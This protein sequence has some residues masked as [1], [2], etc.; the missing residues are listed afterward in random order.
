MKTGFKINQ[1]L[2][3]SILEYL[4]L[5]YLYKTY[6]HNPF[7]GYSPIHIFF[8]LQKNKTQKKIKNSVKK[9]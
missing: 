2:K 7:L 9:I 4:I 8:S 6:C 5:F 3:R 1:A